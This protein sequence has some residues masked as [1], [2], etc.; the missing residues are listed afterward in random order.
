MQNTLHLK[1]TVYPISSPFSTIYSILMVYH[2]KFEYLFGNFQINMGQ[3]QI[4]IGPDLQLHNHQS[5]YE[6][7]GK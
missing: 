7:P 2:K 1:G 3:P 4:Q 6:K 5:L